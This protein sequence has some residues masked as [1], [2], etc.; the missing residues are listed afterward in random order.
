MTYRTFP[1]IIPNRCTG[2]GSCSNVCP[3]NAIEVT[4]REDYMI[5]KIFYGRCIQCLMCVD[6]CPEHA[7][8]PREDY[9]IITDN[10]DDLYYEVRLKMVKC[11]L[12]GKYFTTKRSLEK[13]VNE[14]K[15]HGIDL[16]EDMLRMCTECRVLSRKLHPLRIIL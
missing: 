2:C 1:K 9:N 14:L 7:I 13:L 16:S 6:T 15:S 4:Q 3:A 11:E 10:I 12:C 8:T 5:V